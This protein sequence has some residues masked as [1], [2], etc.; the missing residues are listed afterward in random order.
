MAIFTL[1]IG[2]P[3]V[4]LSFTIGFVLEMVT[5]YIL[6]SYY[7]FMSKPNLKNAGGFLCARAFNYVLQMAFLWLIMWM[8][9]DEYWS[10]IIS[11]N[12]AGIINYFVLRKFFKKQ[13]PNTPNHEDL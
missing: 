12:L 1:A 8:G 5:N 9:L 4:S 3:Q 10:G 13:K 6:Q 7:V 11:I 2:D